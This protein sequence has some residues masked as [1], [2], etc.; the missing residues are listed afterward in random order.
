MKYPESIQRECIFFYTCGASDCDC[1]CMLGIIVGARQNSPFW[2]H[3]TSVAKLI[4]TETLNNILCKR[5][6]RL[7]RHILQKWPNERMY[8]QERADGDGQ[9]L[10]KFKIINRTLSLARRKLYMIRELHMRFGFV[11][12]SWRSFKCKSFTVL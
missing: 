3:S 1:L 4:N 12:I 8:T 11:L 10:C 9:K 2:Q 5:A 7:R 6:A